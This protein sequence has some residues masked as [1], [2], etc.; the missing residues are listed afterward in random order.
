MQTGDFV[1][2]IAAF[3]AQHPNQIPRPGTGAD[4]QQMAAHQALAAQQ[5]E[6]QPRQHGTAAEAQKGGAEQQRS[7]G[8][9]RP[10]RHQA[11]QHLANNHGRESRQRR[12]D[13]QAGQ[14]FGR[15]QN[16]FAAIQAQRIQKQQMRR[17]EQQRRLDPAGAAIQQ[18]KARG[19]QPPERRRPNQQRPHDV[20]QKHDRAW[21]H[22]FRLPLR[23]GG[24]LGSPGAITNRAAVAPVR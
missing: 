9:L 18:G 11:G 5:A 2:E 12:G 13:R 10:I 20:E 8:R 7:V 15:R 14:R 1:A 23:I 4:H 16:G 21:G 19:Q 24:S 6:H 17:R 22:P 3:L